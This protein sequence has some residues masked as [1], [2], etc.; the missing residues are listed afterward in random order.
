[1]K[2]RRSDEMDE[3]EEVEDQD[4]EPQQQLV[5]PSLFNTLAATSTA[6]DNWDS[7]IVPEPM[8]QAVTQGR[9]QVAPS[10]SQYTLGKRNREAEAGENEPESYGAHKKRRLASPLPSLL[11]ALGN[12]V[13]MTPDGLNDAAEDQVEVVPLLPAGELANLIF[14]PQ[15]TSTPGPQVVAAE[16]TTPPTRVP[17]PARSS[18]PLSPAP[19]PNPSSPAPPPASPRPPSPPRRITRSR[20]RLQAQ[21][22]APVPAPQP[23]TPPAQPPS[24]SQLPQRVRRS[25]RIKNAQTKKK[26]EGSQA[27]REPTAQKGKLAKRGKRHQ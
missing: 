5:L 2:R 20:A 7:E 16:P 22:L 18:S 24:S 12:S 6:F 26:A 13:P 3:V 10:P 4:D 27:K 1:M 11:T 21:M 17:V 14:L 19:S 25:S 23:P 8:A 9:V 15:A